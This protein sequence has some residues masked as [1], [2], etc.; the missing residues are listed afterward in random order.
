MKTAARWVLNR[1]LAL[2]RQKSKHTLPNQPIPDAATPT[3]GNTRADTVD[4]D[5]ADAEPIQVSTQ[6]QIAPEDP[7]QSFDAPSSGTASKSSGTASK[8]PSPPTKTTTTIED[9]GQ[10]AEAALQPTEPE[11]M[12]PEPAPFDFDALFAASPTSATDTGPQTAAPIAAPE[13]AAGGED[14]ISSLLPGLTSYAAADAAPAQQQTDQKQQSDQQER[15]DQ[16]QQQQQ[17]Q[18]TTFDDLMMDFDLGD[19][20]NEGGAGGTDGGNGDGA[21]FDENFFDI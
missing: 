12:D 8:T 21:T 7:Q 15:S 19:F 11:S 13:A 1:D 18:D 20:T 10:P 17:Q 16:Q 6:I 9:L 2:L 5:M 3:N 14:G 4:T